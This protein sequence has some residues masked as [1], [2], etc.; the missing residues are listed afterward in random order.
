M[1]QATLDIKKDVF[2]S[3]LSRFIG[4]RYYKGDGEGSEITSSDDPI[5]GW[6][7]S[8]LVCEGLRAVGMVEP[9]F[10]ATANKI[11]DL[12]QDK[13]VDGPPRRGDIIFY[14]KRG[15]GEPNHFT[16]IAIMYDD[17]H[18]LEAGG[19]AN[20]TDTDIEAAKRNA[21]VRIRPVEYPGA[22]EITAVCRIWQQEG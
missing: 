10:R 22:G 9:R 7:C 5:F 12:F 17:L 13:E 3:Y 19:G 8:G 1:E 15:I 16:H 11:F 4:D 6:T 18:I 2:I 21:F 14:G 20:D